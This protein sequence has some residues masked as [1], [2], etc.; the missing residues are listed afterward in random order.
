MQLGKTWAPSQSDYFLGGVFNRA[1]HGRA[2]TVFIHRNKVT[3]LLL[4]FALNVSNLQF[5]LFLTLTFSS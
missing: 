4:T 1:K 5:T 3:D 2:K